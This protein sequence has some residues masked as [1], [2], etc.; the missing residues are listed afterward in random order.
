MTPNWVDEIWAP[1]FPTVLEGNWSAAKLGGRRRRSRKQGRVLHRL[2][3][4]AEQ[5]AELAEV[6]VWAS[7]D[8]SCQSGRE[9]GVGEFCFCFEMKYYVAVGLAIYWQ[10]RWLIWDDMAYAV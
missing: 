2:R 6:S 5:N 7:E 9:S 1:L 4:F 10:S 8:V 3:L